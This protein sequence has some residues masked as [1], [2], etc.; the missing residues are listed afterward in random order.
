VYV[1]TIP[2]SQKTTSRM[3]RKRITHTS[4]LLCCESDARSEQRGTSVRS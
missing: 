1:V 3:T 4:R 2:S